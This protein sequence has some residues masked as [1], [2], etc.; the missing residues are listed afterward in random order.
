MSYATPR[1]WN[2]SLAD[3]MTEGTYKSKNPNR[4]GFLETTTEEARA[5]LNSDT[6]G[7]QETMLKQMPDGTTRYSTGTVKYSNRTP[8][9]G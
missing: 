7:Y 2:G 3:G 8:H 4:G 1:S 6:V 5:M 9:Q